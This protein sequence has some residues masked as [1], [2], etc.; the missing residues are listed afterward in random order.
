MS[1]HFRKKLEFFKL[2]IDSSGRKCEIEDSED[3]IIR[4]HLN[5]QY[6]LYIFEKEYWWKWEIKDLFFNILCISRQN[7]GMEISQRYFDQ[8]YSLMSLWWFHQYIMWYNNSNDQF[9]YVNRFNMVIKFQN[10]EC[11][12][13]FSLWSRFCVFL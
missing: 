9:S 12:L 6:N 4:Y 7:F 8:K 5:F 13:H 2:K 3:I 11:I 10:T 1:K